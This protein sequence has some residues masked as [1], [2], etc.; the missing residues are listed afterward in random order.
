VRKPRSTWRDLPH[1]EASALTEACR[2][3][4]ELLRQAGVEYEL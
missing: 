2:P 4:F 3:G 1:D